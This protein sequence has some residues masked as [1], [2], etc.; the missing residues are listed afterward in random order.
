[1]DLVT[2]SFNIVPCCSYLHKPLSQEMHEY[3][4]SR[5]YTLPEADLERY[6]SQLGQLCVSRPD[7]A[8]EDVLAGLCAQSLR[9]A[10]KVRGWFEFSR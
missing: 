6:L 10:V 7:P 4:C 9:V 8:L 5:L 1:M 3:L 2:H